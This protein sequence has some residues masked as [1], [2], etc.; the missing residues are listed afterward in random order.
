VN[1]DGTAEYAEVGVTG[2]PPVG[3]TL[4][5]VLYGPVAEGAGRL[6]PEEGTAP[7]M[8]KLAQPIRV[9]LAKW[10]TNERSPK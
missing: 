9:L 8:V 4:M 10:R 2:E 5:V 3:L 1:C 7:C 6:A